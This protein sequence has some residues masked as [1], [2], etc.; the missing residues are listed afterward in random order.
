MTML[1][2][3]KA[4]LYDQKLST[5]G[6]DLGAGNFRGGAFAAAK[7]AELRFL[8]P[9]FSGDS[10]RGQGLEREMGLL[11]LSSRK[12][13]VPTEHPPLYYRHALTNS[14]SYTICKTTHFIP[15][16]VP[17]LPFENFSFPS[18]CMQSDC[19]DNLNCFI[20]K[21]YS[22][23]IFLNCPQIINLQ[24]KIQSKLPADSCLFCVFLP[25]MS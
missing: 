12:L 6:S 22:V 25:I 7:K 20:I 21:Q 8:E 13:E 3:L 9:F 14:T 24:Y 5:L 18:D 19:F 2:P 16:S 10:W 17:F 11:R 23:M 4:G 1:C 15:T